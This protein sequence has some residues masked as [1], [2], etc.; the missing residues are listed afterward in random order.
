MNAATM[1]ANVAT[2]FGLGRIGFA[3]GT[4]GSLV[5]LPVAWLAMR[6]AGTIGLLALCAAT[7]IL[8]V[9]ASAHYAKARETHDPS[10]CI[11]DEVA[12]QFLA[13][14]L[15]PLSLTGFVAAFVF[16]RLFDISKLWPISAV[17]RIEG[18]AGIVGDDL[19]A[20]LMAGVVTAV[21]ATAGFL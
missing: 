15:S 9:W 12:G 7:S 10:E 13:C 16:F 4:L 11:I 1:P 6:L 21:F 14:A 8:A 17:E 2:L 5:A 20:G 18:G 19:I 3:P